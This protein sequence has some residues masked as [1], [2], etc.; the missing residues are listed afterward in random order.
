[1]VVNFD[2]DNGRSEAAERAIKLL[3]D[4]GLHV[5]VLCPRRRPRSGRIVKQ[6]GAEAYRAKLDS[7]SGYFHWLADRARA[8]FDMRSADGRMDASNFWFPR[9]RKSPTS[10]SAPRSPAT[11]AA[12]W[13]W[14]PGW[15]W[16]NSK[17]GGERSV[18]KAAARAPAIPPLERDAA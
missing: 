2:P 8:R 6:K 10:W 4:E 7:A 1:M 11:G 5:R 12:I 17:S 14:T 3:L 15:C 16:I 9:C 13:A 18:P